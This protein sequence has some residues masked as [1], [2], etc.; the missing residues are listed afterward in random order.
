M[1]LYLA[2]TNLEEVRVEGHSRSEIQTRYN[3]H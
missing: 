3:L 2:I 1:E